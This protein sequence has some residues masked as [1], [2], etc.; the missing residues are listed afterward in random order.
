MGQQIHRTKTPGQAA[1]R[2]GRRRPSRNAP[3]RNAGWPCQREWRALEIGICE[4][5]HRAECTFRDHPRALRNLRRLYRSIA[6]SFLARIERAE[7]AARP[8][9]KTGTRTGTAA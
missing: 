4:L 3:Y 8:E 7:R 6:V 9:R 2:S 5:V 1:R